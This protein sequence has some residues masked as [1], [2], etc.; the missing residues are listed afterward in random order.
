MESSRTSQ[1]KGLLLGPGKT[2][3]C[4]RVNGQQYDLL[5][6]PRRTLLDALRLDL[7]L[8]GSKQGCDNGQCGACTVLIDGQTAYSCL[9]LA[10]E[11]QE[12]EITTIEGIGGD[13]LHPIQEAFIE[14]DGYQC[15]FCTPGQIL[16]AK[17]LLDNVP[18]P[19]DAQIQRAMSGNLCRCGAYQQIVH[20][21]RSAAGKLQGER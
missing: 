9:M 7:G 20:S 4:L 13:G 12:Y 14:Q 17:A 16:S 11:C 2:P 10:I 19:T 1:D 6:E 21:V 3:V 8:T 15:G 5:I 18:D